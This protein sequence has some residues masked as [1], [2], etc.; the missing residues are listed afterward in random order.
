MFLSAQVTVYQFLYEII[1]KVGCK[2][3][4][5]LFFFPNLDQ[6]TASQPKELLCKQEFVSIFRDQ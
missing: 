2:L 5:H 6:E 4:T 3:G 1:S